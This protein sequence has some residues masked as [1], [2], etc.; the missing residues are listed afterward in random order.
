[1]CE[2]ARSDAIFINQAPP[3]Q[4]AYHTSEMGESTESGQMI[5]KMFAAR[6]ESDGCVLKLADRVVDT[7]D[8]I[9]KVHEKYERVLEKL[10]EESEKLSATQRE[11]DAA[12]YKAQ[13]AE[14]ELERLKN[15]FEEQPAAKRPRPRD[16]CEKDLWE[17]SNDAGYKRR[18]LAHLAS[19]G[20][21]VHGLTKKA[22]VAA[23]R[24]VGDTDADIDAKSAVCTSNAQRLDCVKKTQVGA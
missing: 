22:F 18:M 3:F 13:K 6:A 10:R 1:M 12:L 15:K 23:L 7:V 4:T 21:N 20:C 2:R 5:V 14:D 9:D 19:P 8:K 16:F 17:E 11:R 24:F